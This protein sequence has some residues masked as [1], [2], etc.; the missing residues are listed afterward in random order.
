L[1][2]KSAKDRTTAEQMRQL[3]VTTIRADENLSLVSIKQKVHAK[4]IQQ[5]T[6]LVHGLVLPILDDLLNWSLSVNKEKSSRSPDLEIRN[7]LGGF[8]TQVFNA[9]EGKI[10]QW[11]SLILPSPLFQVQLINLCFVEIRLFVLQ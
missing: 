4:S 8:K 3:K 11:H 10:K 6:T 2:D 1:E 9:L 5:L 7:R